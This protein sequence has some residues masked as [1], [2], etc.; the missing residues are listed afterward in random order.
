METQWHSGR[1]CC[2]PTK[3]TS[4]DSKTRFIK[5]CIMDEFTRGMEPEVRRYFRKIIS[6]VSLVS[7]WLLSMATAGFFFKLAIVKDGLRWYNLVF[8]AILVVTLLLLLLYLYRTWISGRG[9]QEL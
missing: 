9:N 1:F 6:S 7:I 3:R 4:I 5:N 2:L 8:Y